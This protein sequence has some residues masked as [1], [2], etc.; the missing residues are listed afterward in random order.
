METSYADQDRKLASLNPISTAEKKKKKKKGRKALQHR[1]ETVQHRRGNSG[2]RVGHLDLLIRGGF[3][4]DFNYY[5]PFK[6]NKERFDEE[7][8]EA[9]R[10]PGATSKNMT[11]SEQLSDE[12]CEDVSDDELYAS[13]DK[14]HAS[15]DEWCACSRCEPPRVT[16]ED[17]LNMFLGQE[18]RKEEGEEEEGMKQ[19]GEKE[20]GG[21]SEKKVEGGETEE[22]DVKA[23]AKKKG[24]E[25]KKFKKERK[26]D[27]I[28]K[29]VR[30]IEHEMIE[31]EDKKKEVAV[32]HKLKNLDDKKQIEFS[33]SKPIKTWQDIKIN[34]QK[35][36]LDPSCFGNEIIKKIIQKK[37]PKRRLKVPFTCQSELP[38]RLNQQMEKHLSELTSS[39]TNHVAMVLH[40][41][42]N[43]PLY[44][45]QYENVQ[46]FE[47][48][49]SINVNWAKFAAS[50]VQTNTNSAKVSRMLIPVL[51][52]KLVK[53]IEF[54]DELIYDTVVEYGINKKV[55]VD[56]VSKLGEEKEEPE[57]EEK[58]VKRVSAIV[59]N[60]VAKLVDTVVAD[61]E[62]S[63][64]V[65]AVKVV[66]EK[67]VGR[68][69]KRLN[70]SY[71]EL[72]EQASPKVDE[73]EEAN[74]A[75]VEK[76]YHQTVLKKKNEIIFL[77][78]KNKR[79][80]RRPLKLEDHVLEV[81]DNEE[82]NE[83]R[84]VKCRR[85]E[86][87]SVNEIK[88]EEIRR[89]EASVEH[90]LSNPPVKDCSVKL[91]KS[92]N[93]DD[94]DIVK[95]PNNIEE[96]NDLIDE[97]YVED[98]SPLPD[99][100]IKV[101]EKVI[102]PPMFKLKR[103]LQPNSPPKKKRRIEEKK[104]LVKVLINEEIIE[105][106]TLQ[107]LMKSPKASDTNSE[108]IENC[109]TLDNIF[110]NEQNLSTVPVPV[111]N[112]R[113]NT[114][115]VLSNEVSIQPIVSRKRIKTIKPLRRVEEP[116]ERI[117]EPVERIEEPVE[118]IEEPV[119]RIEEPVERI[120]EPVRSVEEPVGRVEERAETVEEPEMTVK[121]QSV[122]SLNP[123][124][125]VIAKRRA[126]ISQ[127]N[128]VK[129]R[130][131]K[132]PITQQLEHFTHRDNELEAGFAQEK[133]T[134][135]S[136]MLLFNIDNEV[137][138]IPANKT[139]SYRYKEDKY[140]G[141]YFH[142]QAKL[143]AFVGPYQLDEDPAIYI[144]CK[145]KP[146]VKFVGDFCV[147]GDFV[148]AF[149]KCH[150]RE[151]E[152]R[153]CKDSNIKHL[154]VYIYRRRRLAIQ[155][156][157]NVS[158]EADK[159]TEKNR[160]SSICLNPV[161]NFRIKPLGENTKKCIENASANSPAV[162]NKSK[163]PELD[164][165]KME[166][167]FEGSSDNSAVS[168]IIS[169]QNQDVENTVSENKTL[170]N[171]SPEVEKTYSV[172]DKNISTHSS[173]ESQI[174]IPISKMKS[175]TKINK[176]PIM[177][178]KVM[179]TPKFD[180][181][182]SFHAYATNMNKLALNNVELTYK[183]IEENS[184]FGKNKMAAST[185]LKEKVAAEFEKLLATKELEIVGK[186][187][188]RME[189]KTPNKQTKD[190]IQ[191]SNESKGIATIDLCE[192]EEKGAITKPSVSVPVSKLEVAEKNA[193]IPVKKQPT[194][195]PSGFRRIEP[196]LVSPDQ[197]PQK[198]VLKITKTPK[199]ILNP[200]KVIPVSP[201][202][203]AGASAKSILKYHTEQRIL[204]SLPQQ[205]SQQ[206][207][208]AQATKAG[209]QAFN[210]QLLPQKTSPLKEI[211]PQQ[212]IIE[213]S[214]AAQQKTQE[215]SLIVQDPKNA[216]QKML[217][218]PPSQ[219]SSNLMELLEKKLAERN[220]TVSQQTPQEKKLI[221]TLKKTVSEE[222]PSSKI[223]QE[224]NSVQSPKQR[225]TSIPVTAQKT[226]HPQIIQKSLG[227][228]NM[229]QT[230]E[231][232]GSTGKP[233][234]NNQVKKMIRL[235]GNKI[236]VSMPL[237]KP[238]PF[239]GPKC[240]ALQKTANGVVQIPAE[241]MSHV[242]RKDVGVGKFIKI[243]FNGQNFQIMSPSN[244]MLRTN[245]PSSAN[246]Q[247][248][249]QSLADLKASKNAS[250]EASVNT[251]SNNVTPL[252]TLSSADVKTAKNTPGETSINT[253]S[254]SAINTQGKYSTKIIPLPTLSLAN[255]NTA[256]NGSKQTSVDTQSKSS[257]PVVTSF[258]TPVT[259]ATYGRA[260]DEK[261]TSTGQKT[262]EIIDITDD[263]DDTT[264]RKEETSQVVN[265]SEESTNNEE[266]SPQVEIPNVNDASTSHNES[267][268]IE[269]PD[270]LKIMSNWKYNTKYMQSLGLFVDEEDF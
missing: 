97:T 76:E 41:G 102:S 180:N 242:N 95:N 173:S 17:K 260:S 234:L 75:K 208:L 99:F 159:L 187:E 25:K 263:G 71:I 211:T 151:F 155:R 140:F 98:T 59:K 241:L 113:P 7:F 36:P 111:V 270:A 4:I 235:E 33:I 141:V 120:E 56:E 11:E 161:K 265:L 38:Q 94:M 221:E 182:E 107:N 53:L 160:Q 269:D 122:M 209:S 12:P 109:S 132:V 200:L 1:K 129:V 136:T 5:T 119:E 70:A 153:I 240:I 179:D 213:N 172:I 90:E 79:L 229:P 103:C 176:Q 69:L 166:F 18:V 169:K 74:L 52:D 223:I 231:K 51:C 183:Q 100:Q 112:R 84:P 61:E 168:T 190:K 15:D 40:I 139:A 232:P 101:P 216:S 264:A 194:A 10:K 164:I 137:V 162:D 186:N 58:K 210:I 114:V 185:D 9:L 125:S 23:K 62:N 20:E 239:M 152:R 35:H 146:E 167:D 154:A 83:E 3:F 128:D 55:G 201:I 178:N 227:Q 257:S 214:S 184:K 32:E 60:V 80:R 127:E 50:A 256:K 230:L 78:N 105:N 197:G 192:T 86:G 251:S 248:N 77:N 266:T 19:Q 202:P 72:E 170:N 191:G 245:L 199:S 158:Q 104:P 250:S 92:L 175:I 181:L 96:K 207:M 225:T 42:R 108:A 124:I 228:H 85:T 116:V 44:Q 31:L 46:H 49:D 243:P 149:W 24:G 30:K 206:Q 2:L 157:F 218:K 174:S 142:R 16:L 217:Q 121:I 177:K 29:K 22:V 220:Q 145:S 212:K 138:F 89:V 93:L 64:D 150:N 196:K 133:L 47:N 28:A 215:S 73:N 37:K 237:G 123:E 82:G 14:L 233:I 48:A 193:T 63:S 262:F 130:F 67:R 195:Y 252:L 6:V 165:V 189:D 244:S 148:N 253:E 249:T 188:K 106:P 144:K 134:F 115:G 258:P 205:A 147:N 66:S 13:D 45:E 222:H 255:L 81:A 219:V 26:V 87:S 203:P 261:S 247:N 143:T 198:I 91:V 27:D 224:N 8:Y 21:G 43:R 204:Q 117:E 246:V 65:N 238:L 126:D 131:L 156:F 34:R 88:T 39:T 267:S 135:A 163:S 68:E 254:K 118:R 171:A 268:K 259:D 110:F 54:N 226:I 57:C 236:L